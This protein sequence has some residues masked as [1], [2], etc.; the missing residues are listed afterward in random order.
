MA[1]A[2]L[3]RFDNQEILNESISIFKNI[4]EAFF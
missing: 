3:L 4:K 1:L 2:I